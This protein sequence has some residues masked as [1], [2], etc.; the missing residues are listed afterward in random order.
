MR[1]WRHQ[2]SKDDMFVGIP[3][4]LTLGHIESSLSSMLIACLCISEHDV[5]SSSVVCRLLFASKTRNLDQKCGRSSA[6]KCQPGRG[7]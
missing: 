7:N 1:A 4:L 6:T 5:F 3:T 2:L